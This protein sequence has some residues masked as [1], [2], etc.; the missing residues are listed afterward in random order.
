MSQFDNSE[1]E[2]QFHSTAVHFTFTTR[3]RG[4]LNIERASR[5]LLDNDLAETAAWPSE[6]SIRLAPRYRRIDR[7][8]R[9]AEKLTEDAAAAQTADT[10][11]AWLGFALRHPRVAS[12]ILRMRTKSAGHH[13][14]LDL[15][16]HEY[17]EEAWT[18]LSEAQK[19]SAIERAVDQELFGGASRD[20]DTFVRLML[21]SSSHIFQLP[22]TV[23]ETQDVIFEPRLLLAESGEVQ[24]TVATY[25]EAP[26]TTQQIVQLSRSDKSPIIH[27]EIPEP[28][29]A[30]MPKPDTAWIGA[31]SDV[32]NAG[33][34][35]REID[36]EEPFP[37]F[38]ALERHL[39]AV[40]FHIGHPLPTD[41]S[42]YATIFTA[43]GDCCA[44]KKEWLRNHQ[45]DVG[46]VVSRHSGQGTRL[47]PGKDF[48]IVEGESHYINGAASTHLT[49]TEA[50]PVPLEQLRIV[51]LLEYGLL[52]DW[53]LRTLEARA[54]TFQLKERLLSQLYRDCIRLF[55]DLRHGEIKYGT[56]RDV[57]RHLVGE[58]G[59]Y[60]VRDNIERTLELSAQAFATKS[61]SRDSSQSIRLTLL[62]TIVAIIVAVPVIPQFLSAIRSMKPGSFLDFLLVPL[63]WVAEQGDWSTWIVLGV[64]LIATFVQPIVRNLFAVRH[65]RVPRAYRRRGKSW[66]RPPLEVVFEEADRTTTS[67]RN[68]EFKSSS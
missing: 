58:L 5:A 25:F 63:R 66:S 3:V 28:L 52:L 19:V 7:S 68:E 13:D 2:A 56:A 6:P 40:G 29:M 49:I 18:L 67:S 30:G 1:H 53:K 24:L 34:R 51:M 39:I 64:A 35:I 48:S 36:F 9:R 33:A 62:A 12:Q 54:G 11:R 26:L 22:E 60:E 55:I 57:T 44:S 47:H 41:W 38:D 43:V 8:I 10:K 27:S 45:T 50:P 16:P 42:V 23:G 15:S 4:P 17:L 65:F 14:E 61:A 32:L 20:N 31:W 37:L 46:L 21:R 59:G